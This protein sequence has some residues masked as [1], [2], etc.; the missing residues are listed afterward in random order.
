[1]IRALSKPG[2]AL[3]TCT[4][5]TGA[6]PVTAGAN[7]FGLGTAAA[8][9]G[10]CKVKKAACGAGVGHSELQ[11]AKAQAESNIDMNFIVALV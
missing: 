7:C 3:G 2:D 4:S 11:P 8:F 5:N 1:M 6:V 9:I 10:A